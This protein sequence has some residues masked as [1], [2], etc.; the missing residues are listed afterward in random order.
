MYSFKRFAPGHNIRFQIANTLSDFVNVMGSGQNGIHV[1]KI[2]SC[3]NFKYSIVI[4]NCKEDCYFTEKIIDCFLTGVIP[5]YWG[6]PSIGNF[7]D[8]NGFFTF[9]T[10][11]EVREIVENK[12]FL[13]D[14]YTKNKNI[15]IQNFHLALQYKVAEDYL[16]KQYLSPN[17]QK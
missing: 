7:F 2:E 3:K 5:I 9:N 12:N 10:L 1:P 15:I 16:W 13:L 4:E 14:F 11:E 8:K 17:I 6:C